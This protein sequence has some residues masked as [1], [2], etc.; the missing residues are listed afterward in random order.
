MDGSLSAGIG[1]GLFYG[2]VFTFLP[3]M[4]LWLIVRR[5]RSWR[6][7]AWVIAAAVVLAIPNLLTLGIVRGQRQRGP[8]GRAHA[9]RRGARTSARA[10]SRGPIVGR[11]G[12]HRPAVPAGLAPA[13][14]GARAA[15][16]D[17]LR[18]RDEAEGRRRGPADEAAGA[19]ADLL[20]LP[21]QHLPLADGGGG[22]ARPDR[23]G[24]PEGRDRGGE[25][26]HRRRGTSASPPTARAIAEA[27]RRGIAMEGRA[28]QFT[29]GRLRPLRP[30]P[31]DG[32]PRTPPTCAASPP[33]AR[34][35]PRSACCASSTPRAGGDLDV[36]DPYFGGADGFE[37]VFDMVERACAGLLEHL[38]AEPPE[39]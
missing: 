38:R 8:R 26:G 29:R 32:P 35:R 9:R 6:F 11:A 23:R 21:R 19:A 4:V 31:G 15:L 24:R 37:D 33:P 30:R 34:T 5:K 20:R 36:P 17:E 39:P 16:R 3:L 28:R 10:P 2:F 18:T 1:L 14:A 25:R 12:L 27:R 13:R 22:D 7:R